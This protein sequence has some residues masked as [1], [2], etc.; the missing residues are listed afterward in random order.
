M[1]HLL[2]NATSSF[3]CCWVFNDE[4]TSYQQ[5]Q[6]DVQHIRGERVGKALR[7]KF[8]CIFFGKDLSHSQAASKQNLLVCTTAGPRLRE[9]SKCIPGKPK[10]GF[11]TAYIQGR[12]WRCQ[13]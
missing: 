10:Y 8:V 4:M 12:N 6:R 3:S 13:V 2:G 7:F 9:H 1:F 5:L 11:P